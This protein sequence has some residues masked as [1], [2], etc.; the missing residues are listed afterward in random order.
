MR[1]L[2][3]PPSTAAWRVRPRTWSEEQGTAEH[4]AALRRAPSTLAVLGLVLL[5]SGLA[6]LGWLGYQLVGTDV[7]AAQSYRS[8]ARTLRTQWSEDPAP[9]PGPGPRTATG[10][11]TG[12]LS[13]ANALLRIP[14][15]GSDYEVP[16]LE[17]TGSRVL[18][19]GVGHY[20]GTAD[21]GQ[22]GNFSVAGHR[23][24][25]GQPFARLLSLDAGDRV[26]I[27]TRDATYTYVL[28]TSARDLTVEETAGW[29]LDPVP[30]RPGAAP[31]VA[32]ITLTTC[33]DLFHSPDRSVAFGHL[34]HTQ[35]R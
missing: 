20:A 15:L 25:H 23:I 4:G 10:S 16:V 26:V 34:E 27:E 11:E 19:R 35:P 2:L 24:T 13:P 32:R 6:C 28:D 18:A 22:I 9:A 21:A 5:C 12:S 31:D 8:E 33:Q 17:G 1:P 3:P 30:G 14:K 29:V 7:V